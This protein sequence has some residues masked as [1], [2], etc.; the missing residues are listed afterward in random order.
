MA[1]GALSRVAVPGNFPAR[2]PRSKAGRGWPARRRRGRNREAVD[3]S[4]EILV[5]RQADL[6]AMNITTGSKHQRR[7]SQHHAG[8]FG[9]SWHLVQKSSKGKALQ[10]SH[11][12]TTRT[13]VGVPMPQGYIG[14]RFPGV[15][16]GS[17]TDV[18]TRPLSFSLMKASTDST[19]TTA[20]RP[21]CHSSSV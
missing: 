3:Q 18:S 4:L 1:P 17:F 7:H 8:G 6:G 19:L 11:R 21:A 10:M 12:R 5:I 15:V 16:S 9:R 2:S 20:Y 14:G 13:A